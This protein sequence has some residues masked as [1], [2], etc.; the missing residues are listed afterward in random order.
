[1]NL[2]DVGFGDQFKCY[3]ETYIKTNYSRIVNEIEETGEVI[4]SVEYACS[5]IEPI[6]LFSKGNVI[7]FHENT[8]VELVNADSVK[9][10]D[11]PNGMLA[12]AQDAL[13]HFGDTPQICQTMEECAELIQALNKSLRHQSDPEKVR[14][15]ILEE[16]AD[17]TIMIEQMKLHFD[18]EEEFD[19]ILE[20]KKDKLRSYLSE[21]E[22][23]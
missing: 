11:D 21:Q 18:E 20:A 13:E 12:L 4:E 19:D 17:V 7:F 5:C 6:D 1:M 14:H 8:E 22:A 9:A 15:N 2:R 16:L 3:D 10:D 23:D